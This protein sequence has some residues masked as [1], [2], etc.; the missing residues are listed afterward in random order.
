MKITA[1]QRQRLRSRV[2]VF[3]DGEL[4]VTLHR[5]VAAEFDLRPGRSTSQDEL[6]R[7]AEADE[8]RTALDS[9]LRLLSYRP[10]TE[11]ELRDRLRRKGVGRPAVDHVLGRLRAMGYLDDG[12][13]A[14]FW[15]EARQTLRP[16]SGRLVAAELRRHGIDAGTAGEAAAVI[17]D[18][19]AALEAASRRL[20]ALQ[21][22]DYHVFRERLGRFL[23]G[24]GF[25]YEVALKAIDRCWEELEAQS[26]QIGPQFEH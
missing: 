26:G 8:R 22:L 12:A 11:R 10:R 5:D 14:R 25:S 13:F 3:A 23:T 19:D 24:R 18:D 21:G 17:S 1:V 9:A 2:D 6:S 16:R 20:K 7:A 15:V 4:A